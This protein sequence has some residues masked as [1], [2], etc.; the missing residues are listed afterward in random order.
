LIVVSI[1]QFPGEIGISVSLHLE[2][3]APENCCTPRM[4]NRMNTNIKKTTT[5]A[6]AGRELSK[7]PINLLIPKVR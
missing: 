6:R 3:N 2:Y 7:D 1:G 4:P 5:L